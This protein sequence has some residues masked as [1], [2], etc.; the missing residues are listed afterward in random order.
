MTCL[1]L[2]IVR[3]FICDRINLKEL[4]PNW[5]NPGLPVK[6]TVNGKCKYCTYEYRNWKWCVS[7]KRWVCIKIENAKEFTYSLHHRMIWVE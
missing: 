1:I 6:K 7:S 3:V 4:P 5:G 2:F